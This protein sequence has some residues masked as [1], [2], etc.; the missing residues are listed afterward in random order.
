MQPQVITPGD[1]SEPTTNSV[2]QEVLVTNIATS[3]APSALPNVPAVP[4]VPAVPAELPAVQA[5]QVPVRPQ[6]Y[7]QPQPQIP[8]QPQPSSPPAPTNGLTWTASEFI[9]HDKDSGWYVLLGVAA[10]VITGLIYLLTRDKLTSG[11]V[12]IAAILFGIMAA[13]KPRELNYSLSDQGVQVAEKLYPYSSFKS[14][15]V[16]REAGVES[17]WFMPLERFKPGL[18]IYFAPD[19]AERIVD[20]LS[21]A[22]PYQEYELD[23]T[24]RLM[25]HLRF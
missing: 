18:S 7:A 20:M 11:T 2:N 9:P 17:V 14:F 15:S 4:T 10:I 25:H 1:Q 24:D 12:V 22:L 23:F 21:E 6:A 3:S 19:M 8:I 13:R 5:A 16:V